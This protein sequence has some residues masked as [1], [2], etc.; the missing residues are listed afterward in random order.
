ML[1]CYCFD[2]IISMLLP[3]L[4]NLHAVDLNCQ[5][6]LVVM[7]YNEK[8]A[9][10]NETK[11]HSICYLLVCYHFIKFFRIPCFIIAVRFSTIY[12]TN[13]SLTIQNKQNIM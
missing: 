5:E 7:F 3:L 13:S 2:N 4:N 10:E 9:K 1:F 6:F 12:R 8:K 11:S